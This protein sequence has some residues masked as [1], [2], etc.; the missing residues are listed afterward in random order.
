VRG[1][2]DHDPVCLAIRNWVGAS[3]RHPNGLS[4]TNPD[5]NTNSVDNAF[6]ISLALEQSGDA[7]Q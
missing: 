2:D 1:H 5:T 4:D 7:G 3:V 6:A